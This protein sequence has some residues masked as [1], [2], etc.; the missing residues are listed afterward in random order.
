[1]SSA[2][3]RPFEVGTVFNSTTLDSEPMLLESRTITINYPARLEAMAL[4]PSKV[5]ETASLTYTAG[6]IDFCVDLQKHVTV[7]AV[8]NGGEIIVDGSS[9]RAPLVR[10]A[11]W[12]MKKS[13]G[14][15]EGLS[16]SVEDNVPLR[17]CGLGSSSGTIAAVASAINELY[18]RPMSALNL[19]RYCAQNHGEEIDG[20]DSRLVPVQCL[21]GSA[22]CGNV[23]GGLV[24]LTGQ[25]T[26]IMTVDLPDEL[27]VVIGVP[28]DFEHPDSQELMRREQENMAGF[29]S[30]GEERG[31][32]IAYRLVH[33][34][35]PSL[36]SGDLKPCKDLIFDYRWNMG[37]IKNCSF[38]LPRIVEIAEA[39]RP[40]ADDE[41]AVIISLSSVGP[42][43]FALTTNPDRITE[44]FREQQMATLQTTIH[45]GKYSIRSNE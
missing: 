37:S 18:S 13:L 5:A 35:L 30:T 2:A 44:T 6:Q 23:Q 26:P 43:F 17:H 15:S 16:V 31:Q 10:H 41:E 19:G 4:D 14:F 20:D 27:S 40:L 32:E 36:V 22:V 7:Q 3:F 34:V 24:V 25:A 9:D 1:M 8:D 28:D 33:S 12:L 38:V 45:N 39:L 42:G 29:V 11:A 21:G